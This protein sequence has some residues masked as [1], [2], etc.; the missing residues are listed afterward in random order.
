MWCLFVFVSC[1]CDNTRGKDKISMSK[2]TDFFSAYILK[3]YYPEGW[4]SKN[5][6]KILSTE[7]ILN[8]ELKNILGNWSLKLSWESLFIKFPT[9]FLDQTVMGRFKEAQIFLHCLHH[10]DLQ[11]SSDSLIS[12]ITISDKQTWK[13]TA[14]SFHLSVFRYGFRLYLVNLS[15]YP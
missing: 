12:L 13:D 6:L 7:I 3:K 15:I 5:E 10:L 9:Q 1:I 11:T 14:L 4:S 2:H 8:R